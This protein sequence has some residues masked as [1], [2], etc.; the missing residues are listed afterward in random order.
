M[1]G[2]ALTS[3]W[4]PTFA[5][6][7]RST[8]LP[9]LMW[10]FDMSEGKSV[11][12]SQSDD[13]VSWQGYAD[14]DV[15]IVTQWDDG[16]HSGNEPGKVS[17]SSASMPSVVFRM[18]GDLDVQPGNRVLEIGTGTGWN[19]ALL[20]HR[21]RTENVVTVEVD[22]AVAAR[23]RTALE[24]FGLPVQVV[25]G[26]GFKGYP[27]GAPYDRIIATCGLR[28][29][30][31]AWVQQTRPGGLVVAPWGT[32]YSNSDAVARLV[33]GDGGESASGTFTG[34]VEFMKL[35]AQRL[36]PLVHAE[37]VTGSV[38]D[39][40]ESATTIREAEFLGDQFGPQRFAIGLRVRDCWQVV[41]DKRDGARPVWF[42]GLSDRSWA[43]AMFRDGD[44]ARVWQLGP[45]R[46]WDEA[47]AAYRWWEGKG[48]PGHE[49]F[50]LTVTAEGQTA[51]LD[52]PA[53]TWS[54]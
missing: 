32:H 14:A 47:E 45:R 35:R 3:D 24:R 41:A 12:V 54:V 50:G 49:R 23:A 37:Y 28:S 10:P 44:T 52:D 40:E 17:T 46:L 8:F 4:V 22:E 5:A 19:A 7:P 13:L 2:G 48:K 42:Y 15:P 38:A 51:W 29:I 27:E 43:C 33:V 25:H 9:D 1:S 31:F 30:P 21:L 16:E 6:V 36:P 18:L 11:A 20:A 53:D 26:D 39:G 34:P